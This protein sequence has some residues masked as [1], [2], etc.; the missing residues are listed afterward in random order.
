MRP[1]IVKILTLILFVINSTVMLSQ[2]LSSDSGPPP[3][4][5]NRGPE[6]PIDNSIF[7]LIVLG[8]IYGAYITYKK[9]RVM[10]T[11]S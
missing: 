10:N 5:N 6:L 1:Q 9:Y 7:I 4:T 3:P 2:S 8:L 11:P